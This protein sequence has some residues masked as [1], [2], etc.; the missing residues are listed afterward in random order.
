MLRLYFHPDREVEF[1]QKPELLKQLTK[2]MA[3]KFPSV[4]VDASYGIVRISLP[5]NFCND[6]VSQLEKCFDCHIDD[7]D[8]WIP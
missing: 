4:T 6:L 5:D 2:E 7:E 1:I 3:D 8:A